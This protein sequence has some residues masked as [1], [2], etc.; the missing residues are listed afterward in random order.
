MGAYSESTGVEIIRRHVAEYISKRDGGVESDWTNIILSGGASEAIRSLLALVNNQAAGAKPIGVMIP[1]P[2]YPL[3]SATIAEYGMHQVSY[4]L[5]EANEWALDI[6]ELER[7]LA[8]S[9]EHCQPRV[10]CV[11]NP[12]NPTGSILTRANIAEIVKFAERHGLMLIADEVYQHNIW[13]EGAAFHSFKKVMAEENVKVELASCMSLS[14]GYMGECGVRGGYAELVNFDP[15]VKAIFYK[16]LS[17]KLCSTVLGQI[18][19]DCVVKP[20]EPGEPS[21]ELFKREKDA[22]LDGLKKKAEIVATTFN[23]IPGFKCNPVAGA[24]YAFPQIQLPEKAIQKAK[25]LGQHPDFYYVMSLLE[26][27]G[28]CIVP[29]SF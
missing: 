22:V 16:M 7:A 9:R 28:V 21:Y 17:A 8:E 15:A 18:G 23:S 26:S 3:Y 10:L 29:G 1:I 6:A 25:S 2:Q 4:Y 24:M 14:K 11:I 19:I 5:D 20:P 12:G 13:K 27:T